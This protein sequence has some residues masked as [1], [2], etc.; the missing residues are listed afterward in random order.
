MELKMCI[1]E[2]FSEAWKASKVPFLQGGIRILGPVKKVLCVGVM[3]F[4]TRMRLT[5]DF[6]VVAIY[7]KR[8]LQYYKVGEVISEVSGIL[9]CNIL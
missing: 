9:N 6:S 7:S 2:R 5:P 1:E 3:L 4:L 8:E